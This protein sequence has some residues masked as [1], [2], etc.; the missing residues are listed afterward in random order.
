MNDENYEIVAGTESFENNVELTSTSGE[1]LAICIDAAEENKSADLGQVNCAKEEETIWTRL[2]FTKY[3]TGYIEESNIPHLS[4]F[5]LFKEF[6]WFGC[7]AFGGKQYHAC[8][9]LKYNFF[10]CRSSFANCYDETR[11]GY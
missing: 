8:F 2:G 10:G 3:G 9:Q 4:Y 6:L 7:R 11:T 5:D 1:N